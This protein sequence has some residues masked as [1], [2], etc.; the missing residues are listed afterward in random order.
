MLL[1]ALFERFSVSCVR[2]FF[3]RDY[4][5]TQTHPSPAVSISCCSLNSLTSRLHN[6]SYILGQSPQDL[7][8]ITHENVAMICFHTQHICHHAWKTVRNTFQCIIIL[9]SQEK[10]LKSKNKQKLQVRPLVFKLFREGV[11]FFVASWFMSLCP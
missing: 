9:Q 3:N 4:R 7:S 6:L 5:E 10:V 8:K 1:S 11:G 2:D